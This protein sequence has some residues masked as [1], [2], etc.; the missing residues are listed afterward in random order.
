MDVLSQ[1]EKFRPRRRPRNPT[2]G[3]VTPNSM[4]TENIWKLGW[5]RHL[6]AARIIRST[7]D[8]RRSE[9]LS[10]DRPPWPS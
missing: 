5:V 9:L 8:P 3:E 7:L 4:Y 2:F 10:G 6:V 1:T